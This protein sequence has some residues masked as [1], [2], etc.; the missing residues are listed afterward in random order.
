MVLALL[1]QITTSSSSFSGTY[2]IIVL[3][4]G[5]VFG[6]ICGLLVQ[7]G[8][9]PFWLGFILGFFLGLI[10]LIIAIVMHTSGRGRARRAPPHG[11]Y[12]PPD[13][14]Q[15]QNPMLSQPAPPPDHAYQQGAVVCSNCKAAVPSG[16]QYCWNCGS[17]VSAGA[18]GPPQQYAPQ[19]SLPQAA[20]RNKVCSLCHY[21]STP[22]T[23]FCPNC[24][25]TLSDG[26]MW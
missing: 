23:E 12:P 2:I 25:S 4:V 19:P 1:G 14:Y 7:G 3:V 16:E 9:Y 17:M 6:V 11:L 13:Y 22:D 26:A 20:P 21:S 5:A 18:P 10:G 15:Q 24:G 8:D